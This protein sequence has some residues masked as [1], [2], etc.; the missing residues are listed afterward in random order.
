MTIDPQNNQITG[1]PPV[2]ISNNSCPN[3]ILAEIC[4]D[5]WLRS[6]PI[7]I[8]KLQNVGLAPRLR[9]FCRR[10]TLNLSRFRRT[11]AKFVRES[12][13]WSY[14]LSRINDIAYQPTRPFFDAGGTNIQ[15]GDLWH[16]GNSIELN[17]TLLFEFN[18]RNRLESTALI[19]ETIGASL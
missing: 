4:L 5:R 3:G 1:P 19:L 16:P 2:C 17:R 12:S 18:G 15:K 14:R 10:R 9:P 7:W 11:V 6:F 8:R 13:A